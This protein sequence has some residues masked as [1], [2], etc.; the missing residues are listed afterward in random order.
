VAQVN[1]EE[2]DEESVA[3][4]YTTIKKS[5]GALTASPQHIT[6]RST[7]TKPS[8]T[9]NATR[10]PRKTIPITIVENLAIDPQIAQSKEEVRLPASKLNVQKPPVAARTSPQMA[11]KL[12]IAPGTD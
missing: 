1:A 4:E 10:R 12:A 5:T 3:E 6:P 2:E 9:T 8:P 11:K 7:T